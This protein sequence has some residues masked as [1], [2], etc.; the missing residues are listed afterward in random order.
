MNDTLPI[1]DISGLSASSKADRAVVAKMLG[2]ACRDTGFFAITGHGVP[3]GTMRALFDASRRFFALPE[4][5]RAALSIHRHGNNRGYF[6]L[7]EERLDPGAAPDRKEGFNIGL[8]LAADDPEIGRPFRGINPWPALPGWRETMLAHFERCLSIGRI[9]HRGFCL[10]LGLPEDFFAPA[11]DRSLATLRLLRYPAADGVATEAPGA[12]EHTD[13]GN[14]TI[15]AVEGV[16]GLELRR[17]DGVWIEAPCVEGAFI[18]NI[19]DC[20]MRWTNDVYVSTPH[21][22]RVPERERLSIAFFLDPNP[23]VVVSPINGDASALRRYPPITG[24]DYLRSRLDAT[25][26]PPAVRDPGDVPVKGAPSAV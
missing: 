12:G 9:L 11:L 4:P 8:D 13:Y 16:A 10:D 7:A 14:I 1:I 26:D 24:A 22:V 15:L 25:Y 2:R 17:R 23:D 20:L 5:D 19:G 3:A 6:G 18:V 21:R